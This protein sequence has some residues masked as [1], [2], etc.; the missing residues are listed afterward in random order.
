[1]VCS[2]CGMFLLWYVLIVL[3]SYCVLMVHVNELVSHVVYRRRRCYHQSS[4]STPEGRRPLCWSAKSIKCGGVNL[5]AV[6][7]SGEVRWL[8]IVD[9]DGC[10]AM[11]DRLPRL[12]ILESFSGDLPFFSEM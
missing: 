12:D 2:D 10:A 1:M 4:C 8:H 3:C 7:L 5:S 6:M 9:R 11:Q